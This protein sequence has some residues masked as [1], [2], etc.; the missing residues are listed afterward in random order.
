MTFF[1]L[2]CIMGNTGSASPNGGVVSLGPPKPLPEDLPP[3][4]SN[5]MG[6]RTPHSGIRT[7]LY[8]PHTGGLAQFQPRTLERPSNGLQTPARAPHKLGWDD[9]ESP[10]IFSPQTRDHRM[11]G[12]KYGHFSKKAMVPKSPGEKENIRT[13]FD[14]NASRDLTAIQTPRT[15]MSTETSPVYTAFNSAFSSRMVSR[16]G[17]LR[18]GHS[19]YK[20]KKYRAPQP[21]FG[22]RQPSSPDSFASSSDGLRQ[23][24]RRKKRRAPPPPTQN[25]DVALW[26]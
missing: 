14:R 18:G 17:S 20:R 5:G 4:D 7:P 15:L 13:F 21:P 26:T 22:H 1:N 8:P 25:A 12:H 24:H 2:L 6:W 3:P 10:L 9:E 16:T 19:H 11:K 23:L